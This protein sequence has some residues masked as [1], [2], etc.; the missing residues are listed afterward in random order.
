M[1]TPNAN[2]SNPL[3]RAALRLHDGTSYGPNS[4]RHTALPTPSKTTKTLRSLYALAIHFYTWS[5]ATT[6]YTLSEPVRAHLQSSGRNPSYLTIQI[7][8]V[9]QRWR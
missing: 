3:L 8:T 2:R 5:S 6:S 1:R 9:C 4:F 7:H